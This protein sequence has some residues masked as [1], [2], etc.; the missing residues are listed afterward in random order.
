MKKLLFLF[1]PLLALTACTSEY[2]KVMNDVRRAERSVGD[3]IMF[4]ATI[5]GSD[6][7]DS[8]TKVYAD[9]QLRVLWNADDRISIFNKKTG[10]QEFQFMGED[11]AKA[12]DF[13]P[14][15]ISD[16]GNSLPFVYAVY[17]YAPETSIDGD[18]LISLPSGRT[19]L[20]GEFLR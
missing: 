15:G 13:Q 1:L 7:A 6:D 2:D 14:A 3:D 17:P 10:N 20:S 9:S 11:G 12:G 19:N 16:S 18:G 4:Y 5:E 8:Q